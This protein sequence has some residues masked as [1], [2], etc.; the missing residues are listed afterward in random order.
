MNTPELISLVYSPEALYLK[1]QG[2][3]THGATNSDEAAKELAKE[4]T[5]AAFEMVYYSCMP[6]RKQASRRR[7]DGRAWRACRAW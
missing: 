6:E 2:I 1:V 7:A 4:I 3:I 5:A